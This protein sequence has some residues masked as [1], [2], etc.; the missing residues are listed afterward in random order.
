MT[1]VTC[2][3]PDHMEHFASFDALKECF[4]TAARATSEAVVCC[5]DNAAAREV[6]GAASAPV[7]TYGFSDNADVRCEIVALYADRS[8]FDLVMR[9][10]LRLR[11]AIG[12][13]GR[14]NVLNA[15][16]AFAACVALGHAPER[17]AE[18]LDS[19]TEL[20]GRRYERHMSPCGAEIVSDYAHH[21]TEIAML[22]SMA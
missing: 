5:A 18:A 11:A 16:G 19:L 8:V 1:V 3:E 22:V 13:P 2:V 7:T 10:G 20:P 17:V 6:A 14:H 12:V 15:T 4:A 21:P 9:A